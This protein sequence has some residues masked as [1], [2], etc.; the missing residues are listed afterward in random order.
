MPIVYRLRQ[1]KKMATNDRVWCICVADYKLF[2]FFTD[3]GLMW[4]D[5]KHNIWR[6]VSGDMPRKLYGGAMVEYYGKLAVFW[7]ERISNQK[8]EKIRC[9]VIALARVGEE[10]VRGTI[11]W[12]GVVATIPYV[13]GFLHCLVASD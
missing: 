13:C 8:Q 11:E 2:A 5:T 7:R 6:V 12:S 9:A 1:G 4:L 10:E 3:C